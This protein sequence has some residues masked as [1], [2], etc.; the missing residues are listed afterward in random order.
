MTGFVPE[1]IVPRQSPDGF[2]RGSYSHEDQTIVAD[3]AVTNS[4]EDVTLQNHDEFHTSPRR[5]FRGASLQLLVAS[6][7]DYA[8]LMLDPAG[9]I[10]T[11]NAGAQHFNGY[12]ASGIIGQHF[13]IFCPE[14]E[15]IAG[16]PALALRAALDEGKFEDEGW[17]V[18]RDG[19]QFWTSVVIDPL[20]DDSAQFIEFA[21]IKE[22]VATPGRHRNRAYGASVQQRRR[23]SGRDELA[24]RQAFQ[25]MAVERP[26]ENRRT[27]SLERKS[28]SAEWHEA[29]PPFRM[30]VRHSSAGVRGW[31]AKECS[32]LRTERTFQRSSPIVRALLR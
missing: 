11:W 19:G 29:E 4:R 1:P 10:R 15:Q 12:A 30:A 2:W 9:F 25:H 27:G 31:S 6:V 17:R 23:I 20:H 16:R 26:G 8:I 21:G 24:R 5:P 18:R 32:W 28:S 7:R 3:S 22:F 14:C 13:S